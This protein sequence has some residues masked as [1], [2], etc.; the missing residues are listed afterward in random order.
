MHLIPYPHPPH[1]IIQ[2][3]TQIFSTLVG[4]SKSLY[5]EFL[6]GHAS[7]PGHPEDHELTRDPKQKTTAQNDPGTANVPGFRVRKQTRNIVAVMRKCEGKGDSPSPCLLY[8]VS[9]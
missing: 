3:N 1:P 4:H 6:E 7:V 2:H 5:F 8:S 9:P